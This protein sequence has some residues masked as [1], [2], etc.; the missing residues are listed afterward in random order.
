MEVEY[1]NNEADDNAFAD[2]PDAQSVNINQTD[3]TNTNSFNSINSSFNSN[4]NNTGS[5]VMQRQYWTT[6]VSIND[7]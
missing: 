1:R 3:F 5:Q 7:F 4:N 2:Q 6:D